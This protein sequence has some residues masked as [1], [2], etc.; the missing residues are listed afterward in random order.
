ML[1]SQFE[2]MEAFYGLKTIFFVNQ[3][4]K[5]CIFLPSLCISYAK[6]G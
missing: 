3:N 6:K 2:V 5:I 1:P 4:L